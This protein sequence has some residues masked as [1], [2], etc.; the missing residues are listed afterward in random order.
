MVPVPAHRITITDPPI[1]RGGYLCKC[2]GHIHAGEATPTPE[3]AP[4]S[5]D[6]GRLR[7]GRWKKTGAAVTVV[8]FTDLD[9]RIPLDGLLRVSNGNG[10]WLIPAEDLV[11]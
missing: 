11:G 3:P 6:R 4:A 7:E 2:A 1:C 10:S 5:I 9:R 8:D